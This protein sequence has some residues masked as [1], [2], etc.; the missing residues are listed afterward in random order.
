VPSDPAAGP[1]ATNRR[2]EHEV[3]AVGGHK[4]LYSE[5]FY[6]ESEFRRLYGGDDYAALKSR[7]D[8][9]GRLPDLYAK[10]VGGA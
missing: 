10:A 1:G 5:S 3:G 6:D 4:S 9:E 2:I 7:W 8:P